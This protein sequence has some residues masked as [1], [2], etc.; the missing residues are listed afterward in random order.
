MS[1]YSGHSLVSDVTPWWWS[2]HWDERRPEIG[3]A[4][5]TIATL[6]VNEVEQIEV[7]REHV[8]VTFAVRDQDDPA[9]VKAYAEDLKWFLD[10]L[11][12]PL[13]RASA[14]VN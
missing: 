5:R 2:G 11:V 3:L 7:T 13:V 12:R 1:R 10:D 8:R 9:S 6:S 4:L 14:V